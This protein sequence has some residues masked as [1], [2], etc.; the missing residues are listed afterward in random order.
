MAS[1]SASTEDTSKRPAFVTKT[2]V[3]LDQQNISSNPESIVERVKFD[4]SSLPTSPTSEDGPSSLLTSS[5]G[6]GIL[7]RKGSMGSRQAPK[8]DEASGSSAA[9]ARKRSILKYDSFEVADDSPVVDDQL[10]PRRGVLKKDSSYDD[11]LK[12]IIKYP[13]VSETIVTVPKGGNESMSSTTSSEDLENLIDQSN[14]GFVNVNIDPLPKSMDESNSSASEEDIVRVPSP[15]KSSLGPRLPVIPPSSVKITSDGN[16][17]CKLEV[18][19]GQAEA[20]LKQMAEA[21]A[22]ET[23]TSSTDK[24]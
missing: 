1:A 23:S 19:S 4:S 14:R 12:P 21:E 20:K 2:T 13:L 10:R 17:A 11:T 8:Q 18:L 15:R 3:F 16:L 22:K 7:K 5:G 24:K 9:N 6:G